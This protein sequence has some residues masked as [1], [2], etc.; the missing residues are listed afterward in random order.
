MIRRLLC[1]RY[2]TAYNDEPYD[3]EK[4]PPP[5]IMAPAYVNRLYLNAQMYS[6][7]DK[8][9]I[10]SLK[11][12]AV[13][14]FETAIWEIQTLGT[15]S[16]QTGA[17]LLDQMIETVP[18][19]YSSTPDSDRCLRDRAVGVVIWRRKQIGSHAGLRNLAAAVPEFFE[20]TSRAASSFLQLNSRLRS[21]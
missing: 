8:Y 19:I 1:Y 6:I 13:D 9:D 3:D 17:S 2:T 21:I 14:K 4:E 20:D 7:A 5:H 18:Y 16:P 11:E 10:L 15:M 12:K